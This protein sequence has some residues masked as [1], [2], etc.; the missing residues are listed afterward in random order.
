MQILNTHVKSGEV[1][2]L[3][4]ATNCL[5]LTEKILAYTVNFKRFTMYIE[6]SGKKKQLGLPFGAPSW[7]FINIE[8]IVRSSNRTSTSI[9]TTP[10]NERVNFVMVASRT[11]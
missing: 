4:T 1:I 6:R 9:A 5:K 7:A 3:K 2:L 8:R 11:S 10:C